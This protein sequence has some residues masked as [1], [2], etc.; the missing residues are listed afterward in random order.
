MSVQTPSMFHIIFD[1]CFFYESERSNQCLSRPWGLSVWLKCKCKQVAT[2]LVSSN[3]INTVRPINITVFKFW[4]WIYIWEKK[5]TKI[6]SI[7]IPR[8]KMAT[9]NSEDMRRWQLRGLE[10]ADLF[11][12]SINPAWLLNVLS[13]KKRLQEKNCKAPKANITLWGSCYW[14]KR[15]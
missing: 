4:K 7:K 15:K 2:E 9:W 10:R 8:P 13:R 14:N 12:I 5:C 11:L 1:I 3:L 6:Q